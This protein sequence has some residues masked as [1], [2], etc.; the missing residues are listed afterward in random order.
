MKTVFHSCLFN[1]PISCTFS[2]VGKQNCT[3]YFSFSLL[4]SYAFPAN[5]NAEEELFNDKLLLPLMGSLPRPFLIAVFQGINRSSASG[6]LTL[7]ELLLAH[8]E[9]AYMISN[10]FYLYILLQDNKLAFRGKAGRARASGEA[11]C[12]IIKATAGSCLKISC[13]LYVLEK[14]LMKKSSETDK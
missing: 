1:M 8:E 14:K 10:I 2:F 4:L 3:H 12:S 7:E 9:K 5:I 13:I 11:R 6:R